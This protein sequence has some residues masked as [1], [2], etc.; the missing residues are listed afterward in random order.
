MCANTKFSDGITV[1]KTN[2]IEQAD[3]LADQVEAVF[4]EPFD[5]D[6]DETRESMKALI[7][8]ID[9][10]LLGIKEAMEKPSGDELSSFQEMVYQLNRMN[11]RLL[12]IRS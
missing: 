8:N 3:L 7:G 10:N 4:T 1:D 9:D 2:I 6:I 12:E 11:E 5:E